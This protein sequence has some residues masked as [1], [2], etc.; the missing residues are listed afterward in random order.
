MRH[1]KLPWIMAAG[2]FLKHVIW[3]YWTD[4]EFKSRYC[5]VKLS[6]TDEIIQSTL[7]GNATETSAVFFPITSHLTR[8]LSLLAFNLEISSP[9]LIPR[10]IPGFSRTL[11]RPLKVSFPAVRSPCVSDFYIT[12]THK[13]KVW[14]IL[15]HLSLKPEPANAI[16]NICS[17]L[18][19][20]V[21]F[22]GVLSSGGGK[23]LMVLSPCLLPT[24]SDCGPLCGLKSRVLLVFRWDNDQDVAK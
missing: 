15:L 21:T 2:S 3:F 8:S 6:G 7:A 23:E 5:I 12:W 16:V 10:S 17:L 14:G 19:W 18:L 13:G 9:L 22:K 24:Y 11:R 4:T 20:K 1:L